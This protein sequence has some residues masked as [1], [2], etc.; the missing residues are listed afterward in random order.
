[1]DIDESINNDSQQ[2]NIYGSL[3]INREQPEN[4]E[5]SKVGDKS[6]H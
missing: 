3:I 6:M 4:S 1:M 5:A 2:Q